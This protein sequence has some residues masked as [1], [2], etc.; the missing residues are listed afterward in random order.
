MA[1]LGS[2]FVHSCRDARHV[3]QKIAIRGISPAEVSLSLKKVL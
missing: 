3:S 1:V 2:T